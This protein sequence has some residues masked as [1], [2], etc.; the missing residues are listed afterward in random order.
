MAAS[1]SASTTQARYQPREAVG[2]VELGTPLQYEQFPA[3]QGGRF[4]GDVDYTN[5]TYAEPG[6]GVFA[7]VAGPDA[8]VFSLGGSTYAHTL[9]G[10]GLHLVALS[11]TQLAFSGTGS[12]NG[13][14]ITW[15]IKGQVNGSH[16][17][18]TIAYRG[19]AYKVYLTG[20]IASNGSVSG[21][22]KSSQSQA[23]T[24]TMPAGSFVSVLH[25]IAPLKAVDVQGHNASFQFT[26]PASVP[27]LAGTKVT[28]K[29]HDGGYGARHDT[30]RAGV[31]GTTL[32][33]Y[34]IIGGPGITVHA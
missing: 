22:A 9:N 26:I 10:A 28:V 19:S 2:S 32:T 11:P 4:H 13:G 27:G 29:V 24:F 17:T 21:T 1:A 33:P 20:R 23:L 7:P 25:Y 16:L 3:L 18:A 34:P 6:S 31:T 15:T 5:W 30:Y 12:Y 14:G 8:L